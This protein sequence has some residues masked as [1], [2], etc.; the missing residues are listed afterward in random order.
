MAASGDAGEATPASGVVSIGNVLTDRRAPTL[1]SSMLEAQGEHRSGVFE[2]LAEGTRTHVYFAQ[3]KV[4]FAEEGTLGDTLGRVLV[5]EGKLTLEQ[6]TAAIRHMTQRL[7]ESEQMRFGEVVVELGF[8]KLE[9]V[10]EALAAQV[11]HKVVRCLM[12]DQAEFIFHAESER[13]AVAH[14][15]SSVEPLVL[16]ATKLFERERIDR[17]LDLQEDRYPRLLADA[18]ALTL[19]FQLDAAEQKFAELVDGSRSTHVLVGAKHADLGDASAVL[20]A[21]ILGGAAELCPY[22]T[23]VRA[24]VDPAPPPPAPPAVIVAAPVAVA[25]PPAAA[26]PPPPTRAVAATKNVGTPQSLVVPT[27]FNPILPAMVSDPHAAR[28]V[29][30]GAFQKARLHLRNNAIGRALPELQRAAELCPEATEFVLYLRWAES[31]ASTDDDERLELRASL[32]A[33]AAR[34]V[35]QDPQLAFGF[36]V[37]GQIALLDGEDAKIPIR[38]F[39]HALK[40]D[41]EM[42]D[43]ERHLRVATLRSRVVKK[44]N[45][46]APGKKEEQE[47]QEANER[48]SVLDMIAPK[49]GQAIAALQTKFETKQEVTSELDATSEPSSGDTMPPECP[50]PSADVPTVIAVAAP[51]V[52]PPT[53]VSESIAS[54]ERI[55][56]PPKP[57]PARHVGAV[58]A[59]LAVTVVGAA[60]VVV[61]LRRPHVPTGAGPAA[62]SLAANILSATTVAA[63]VERIPVSV[64]S[65]AASV[66]PP[67]TPVAPVASASP[68]AT[69]ATTATTA[70]MTTGTVV[71]PAN[72]MGHRVFLDGRVVRDAPTLRVSC[73]PHVIKVGSAGKEQPI[74]VPCGE[75]VTL[76]P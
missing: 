71:L 59:L 17:I 26:A 67:S 23:S 1:V 52:G 51:D 53:P 29:A 42:V 33:L 4:V 3:G 47:E 68:P 74:A 48:P 30:E 36:F 27:P 76:D 18:G 60:L 6:Y 56:V 72:A 34:A 65:G 25:A 69:T 14:F 64:A 20:A 24:R 39:G 21:L 57:L 13:L 46:A 41:P 9:Q 49:I 75:V 55:G 61:S 37:L 15:P 43:A 16:A 32:K 63:A 38:L 50:P 31:L 2:V 73:G 5:R 28:L 8:L 10:L 58:L 19:A 35:K 62:A 54:S 22:P 45:H 70:D 11:R 44:P 40:L 7:V 66:S 12:Y